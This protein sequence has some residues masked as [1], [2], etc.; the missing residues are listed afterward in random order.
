MPYNH[1]FFVNRM[2]NVG[3]GFGDLRDRLIIYYHSC[4]RYYGKVVDAQTTNGLLKSCD[5]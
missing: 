2:P 5:S 4:F 1:I 3:I